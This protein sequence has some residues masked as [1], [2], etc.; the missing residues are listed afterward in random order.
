MKPTFSTDDS[1]VLI[2]LSAMERHGRRWA[3]NFFTFHMDKFRGMKPTTGLEGDHV[4]FDA[5]VL[6]ERSWNA[7]RI[8]TTE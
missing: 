5:S 4:F 6:P 1:H 7:C 8:P 3:Q 2:L